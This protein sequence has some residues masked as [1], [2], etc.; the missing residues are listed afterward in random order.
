MF[1]SSNNYIKFIVNDPQIDLFIHSL[2]N[3]ISM[4]SL[5]SESANS[6]ILFFSK[7]SSYSIIIEADAFRYAY[8]KYLN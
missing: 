3:S 5:Y 4:N 7:L 2:R 1:F 8:I 6:L